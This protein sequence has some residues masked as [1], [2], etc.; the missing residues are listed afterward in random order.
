MSL[1]QLFDGQQSLQLYRQGITI[2]T[3]KVAENPELRHDLSSAYCAVADLF[4]TDLCDESDAEAECSKA[5][6]CAIEAEETNPEAWQTK[7]R[8]Q[9]IK[10]LF[11]WSH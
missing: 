8:L 3:T 7:A 1:G 2:L 10:S 9:I 6:E 5:I 4:M 11:G